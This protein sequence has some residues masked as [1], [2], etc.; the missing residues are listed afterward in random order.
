V[1]ALVG[2][3]VAVGATVGD[4]TGSSEAGGID[5]GEVGVATA[6]GV[7]GAVAVGAPAT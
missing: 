3:G 7:A 2:G 1:G 5:A 6:P 4:A